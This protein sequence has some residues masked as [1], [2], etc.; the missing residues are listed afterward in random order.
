MSWLSLAIGLLACLVFLSNPLSQLL[1]GLLSSF[2]SSPQQQMRRIPR[3]AVNESLLALD[4]WPANLTCPGDDDRG[5]S[6]HLLSR[7]PLVVYI[8]N[9]LAPAERAHLLEI[10][11]VLLPVVVPSVG[12]LFL[13]GA[14]SL[15]CCHAA[16]PIMDVAGPSET[17]ATALSLLF[18]V[19]RLGRFDRSRVSGMRRQTAS[20]LLVLMRE[21]VQQQ[22][23]VAC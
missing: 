19:G 22:H 1:T 21:E 10:R 9:F 14:S 8:E 12:R 18:V 2:S 6:A 13:E 17:A 3:P 20:R 16:V 11:W 5:Y 7:A 23:D 15:V 4:D